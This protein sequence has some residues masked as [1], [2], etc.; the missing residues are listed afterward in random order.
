MTAPMSDH[1]NHTQIISM[2]CPNELLTMK[3]KMKPQRCYETYLYVCHKGKQ[4][5]DDFNSSSLQQLLT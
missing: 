5:K 1:I 3:E 4:Y 2:Q